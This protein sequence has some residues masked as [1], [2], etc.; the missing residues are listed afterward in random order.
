MPLTLVAGAGH[1]LL[2]AVDWHLM[3]VLLLGSLPGII[4]GSYAAVRVPQTVLRVALASILI[5]VAGNIA[6]KELNLSTST[7]AALVS[8]TGH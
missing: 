4:I 6:S 3:G 7:V 1:W 2:G 8:S 5:V